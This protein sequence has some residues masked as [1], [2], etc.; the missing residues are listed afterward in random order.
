MMKIKT[1]KRL[2]EMTH[3]WFSIK[4]WVG[5]STVVVVWSVVEE[6]EEDPHH[7]LCSNQ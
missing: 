2:L 4:G 1:I 3:M 5:L 7:T 6:E